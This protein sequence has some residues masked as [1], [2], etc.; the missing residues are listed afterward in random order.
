M[1]KNYNFGFMLFNESPHSA[2]YPRQAFL[3]T[4]EEQTKG[5][6]GDHRLASH[7]STTRGTT[8]STAEAFYEAW[9]YGSQAARSASATRGTP[10]LDKDA[11]NPYP[12]QVC[13]GPS[14]RLR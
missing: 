11:F 9:L 7:S 13:N 4:S 1:A 10:K 2:S 14:G 8:P 5:A 12:T 6:A 3:R